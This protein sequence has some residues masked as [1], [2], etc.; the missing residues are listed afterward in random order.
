MSKVIWKFDGP[1]T[2]PGSIITLEMPDGAEIVHADGGNIWV[3]C[4]PCELDDPLEE[5]VFKIYGTGRDIPD[6]AK[7][8][9]TYMS[10]PFVWHIMEIT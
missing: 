9:A 10:P 2:Q 8:V 4:E 1:A 5:R 3:L 6:N 7:H